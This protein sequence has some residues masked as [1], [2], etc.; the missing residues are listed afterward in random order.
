MSLRTLLFSC[1]DLF[2]HGELSWEN[3][4]D[5]KEDRAERLCRRWDRPSSLSPSTAGSSNS[6]SPTWLAGETE[7]R[8]I[9]KSLEGDGQ[10]EGRNSA[11][12]GHKIRV[13]DAVTASLAPLQILHEYPIYNHT[14]MYVLYIVIYT[15]SVFTDV[16]HIGIHIRDTLGI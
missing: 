7:K 1:L 9:C 5:G 15:Y 13:S 2:V 8:S 4:A 10:G 16:P 6:V 3:S 12:C 14:T 11:V